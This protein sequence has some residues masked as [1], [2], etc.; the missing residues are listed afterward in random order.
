MIRRAWKSAFLLVAA[1]A[2][3]ASGPGW[4]EAAERLT[5]GSW[6]QGSGWHVYAATMAN[7]VNNAKVGVLID[8]LA[9]GG[10]VGNPVQVG[11]GK[12]TMA[13]TFSIANAWAYQGKIAYKKAY[14]NLRGLIGGM[15]E[16]YLGIITTNPNVKSISDIKAKKIPV[17]YVTVPRGGLGQWA[18][19]A[20]LGAHGITYED[21]KSWGGSVTHTGFEVIKSRL[22]D[23][24][25][26]ILSH[27][28][29]PGHPALTEIAVLKKGSVRFLEVEDAVR[30]KLLGIGFLKAT[31]PA[32]TFPGQDQ[33]RK[34]FGFT[35]ALVA[36]T[37]M[38]NDT[39]YKI[40]KALLDKIDDLRAG[41]KA[42]KS[43][44]PAKTG[45]QADQMGAPV[46][47]GAVR[48]FKEKGWQ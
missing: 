17:N 33:P 38:D 48:Y 14:P 39:A 8:P 6:R 44:D 12:Y 28:V 15:D 3:G 20:M 25:A 9:K 47:P 36:S 32:N 22:K 23:G 10:G 5:L 41:H 37:N 26:D 43:F 18:T 2:L 16:Y 7:I 13:L 45:W 4:S 31:M 19:S 27:T 11:E 35:T 34:T 42:L 29:N 1:M 24:Q 40:V 21:I 46:H 30:D